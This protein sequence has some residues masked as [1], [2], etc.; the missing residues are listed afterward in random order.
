MVR[1]EITDYGFI[2]TGHADYDDYGHDIVCAGISALSQSIAMSLKKYCKG[3]V[4]ATNGWLM[5]DLERPNN[6]SKK[7]LD[8]LR[9][10]LLEI[11]KE[12]PKHLEV[13]VKKG[14]FK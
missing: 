12:H 6:T 7:L 11:E 9:M 4:K 14:V 13:R 2:I 5:V 1:A 8:T 3:K 10:G